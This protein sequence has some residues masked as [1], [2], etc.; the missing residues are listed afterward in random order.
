[1]PKKAGIVCVILGAVL[2]G[3][4]LLLFAHNRQEDQN[5]GQEAEKLLAEIEA[6]IAARTSDESAEAP[7]RQL[8]VEWAQESGRS[9]EEAPQ[10]PPEAPQ[11]ETPAVSYTHLTL[12]TT[13]Y[14]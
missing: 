13:P 12:P 2:I 1:M 4:A 9:P 3:S 10:Q 6:V 8:D 14:V 11:D 7:S 5:A